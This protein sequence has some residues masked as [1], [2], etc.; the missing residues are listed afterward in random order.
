MAENDATVSAIPGSAQAAESCLS[1][2]LKSITVSEL[3]HFLALHR[4]SGKL[5]VRRRQ[6]SGLI[7]LRS[8]RIIYAASSSVRESFGSI[9]VC[10]RLVTDETLAEAL[11]RQ[12]GSGEK[13]R[14]GAV[15][16]EM[17]AVREEEVA[18]VVRYQVASVLAEFDQWREGFFRFD[19]V[20]IP[21]GDEIEVNA[22]DF[23]VAEGLNTEQVL[24][25]VAA[26]LDE[27]EKGG[28]ESTP[29]AASPEATPAPPGKPA[30]LEGIVE[31]LPTLVLH[32]E[33]SQMMMRRASDAVNRG[34]LFIVR[35]DIAVGIGHF[36]LPPQSSPGLD[37]EATRLS[38]S[39]PSVITEVIERQETYHGPLP[40][41]PGNERLIRLLGG[42]QPSEVL[43]L[44]VL[45]GGRVELVLYGDN[46][47]QNQPIGPFR[48]LELML[49]EAG[50]QIEKEM[51]DARAR[52]LERA[53]RNLDR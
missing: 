40:S 50:V 33:I 52:G 5:V 1:G 45:V 34:I 25:Q 15:L 20:D 21:E 53:R 51:L 13:R 29:P 18:E 32:G 12:Q 23:V 44:P 27:K 35:E 4:K 10:R 38:L 37:P 7:V 3:L 9:L 6:G 26:E 16:V 17:G 43:V 31:E 47:P 30:S 46:A 22:Q 19:T 39:E 14:L 49:G 41:A 11:Q 36:G 28:T 42:E 48:S 24:L 2:A 8:G